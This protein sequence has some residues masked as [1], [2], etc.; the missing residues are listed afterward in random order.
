MEQHLN[1]DELILLHYGEAAPSGAREHLLQCAECRRERE[2]LRKMLQAVHEAVDE[3]V[4]TS[5]LAPQWEDQLWNRM[6]WKLERRRNRPVAWIGIAAAAVLA[7]VIG[8][9]F[10][11]RSVVS[12]K[13]GDQLASNAQG[14]ERVL[15]IVVGEHL[16]RSERVLT[17]VKNATGEA[18]PLLIADREAMEDLVRTN[19][20]YAEAAHAS[21]QTSLANVLEETQPLLLELA[22]VPENPSPQDLELLRRRIEKRGA[23]VKLR[24]AEEQLRQRK[25]L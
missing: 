6:R 16:S 7:L 8:Y 15:F 23:V 19:R 1:R 11:D 25:T 12:K 13:P 4:E 9:Q 20:L 22:H 14:R 2:L 18:P 17:E 21:G 3:S 10:K 5:T 24:L